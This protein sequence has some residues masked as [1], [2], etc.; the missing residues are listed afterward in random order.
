[1]SSA[2]TGPDSTDRLLR[3]AVIALGVVVLA[4]LLLM[5]VTMPM[6]GMMSWGWSGMMNGG[7][8]NGGMM[9]GG[10]TGASPL[11]GLG[12]LVVWVLLLA[13]LG[14]ALYRGFAGLRTGTGR[15]RALEELRLAYARGDLT[16]EEFEERRE[17][18]RDDR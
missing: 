12:V 13:G 1:M 18:L 3:L 15:D 14:Y 7:M 5:A 9:G 10:M 17:R 8:M 16:D 4:P 6:M 11:W 2:A